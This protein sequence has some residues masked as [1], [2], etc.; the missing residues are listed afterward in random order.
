MPA[1]PDPNITKLENDAVANNAGR[2]S[3]RP[4][5]TDDQALASAMAQLAM[6]DRLP[7][8]PDYGTQGAKAVVWTNYF[9]MS[10]G[11]SDLYRY[12]V[13]IQKD[14]E[15]KRVKRRLLE[16]LLEL[17]DFQGIDCAT[18]YAQIVVSLKPFNFDG[19]SRKEFRVEHYPEGGSPIPP[20]ADGE[21]P[22]RT[23]A[24][25]RNAY[26]IRVEPLPT[27]S[28]PELLRDLKGTT[29]YPLKF[30]TVQ[31]LNIIMTR[32]PNRTRNLVGFSG[33]KF[34]PLNGHPQFANMDLPGALTALRGYFTS[35]RTG[36]GRLLLNVNVAT[37]VFYKPGPLL[38]L[39]LD[40]LNADRFPAPG[41]Q[42]KNLDGFL[43]LVKVRTNYLKEKDDKGN[44]KKD[45]RGQPIHMEKFKTIVALAAPNG[46]TGSNIRQVKFTWKTADG[47][48]NV[49]VEEYFQKGR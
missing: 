8:R 45:N 6:I 39:M 19:Q 4:T 15:S 43:R 30:D 18:D 20:P 25:Q 47:D 28:P 36:P 32:A 27:V 24:R 3:Q 41:P 46:A 22:K 1:T 42:Y 29:R 17:P 40:F 2:A 12:T 48:K 11:E 38:G 44:V 35:V 33:N 14:P 21:D 34:Y 5:E 37:T 49:T 31:A 23:A 9:A 13:A 16:I 10:I 7:L 26:T